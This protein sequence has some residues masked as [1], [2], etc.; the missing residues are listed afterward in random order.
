M[1]QQ[2]RLINGV[3][4]YDIQ[5]DSEQRLDV[6]ADHPDVVA[7]LR[8]GYEAWWAKVSG[9]FG[10]TIPITV[11][12]EAGTP[13]RLTAHDWR[14]D[15]V[16]CPWNQSQIRAG[17]QCNGYWELE[18]AVKGRYRFE[19][20]RWPRE[21][22]LAVCA[23]I[24]GP[25]KPFRSEIRTGYGGGR[26]IPFSSAQIRVGGVVQEAAIETEDRYV[27]FTVDLGAGETRLQTALLP[28]DGGP[29]V[30]AYY[31]YVARVT[32]P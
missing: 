27:A 9:Q 26:A 24:P 1:T 5:R 25:L 17:L 31:V 7:A 32:G 14:N 23:G 18:V 11:G 19:L 6:A 15:P 2:W 20:R 4:L 30:G 22:D 3:E 10:G 21:E 8:E 29:P 16:V 28:A 13:E 12:Q